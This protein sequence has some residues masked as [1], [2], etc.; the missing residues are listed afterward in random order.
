MSTDITL[1]A[2]TPMKIDVVKNSIIVIPKCLITG[3][4]SCKDKKQDTKQEDEIFKFVDEHLEFAAGRKKSTRSK[5]TVTYENDTS[6][7]DYDF[8]F[9]EIK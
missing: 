1:N 9:K 4:R 3:Y 8:D 2:S 5:S 6:D 7:E